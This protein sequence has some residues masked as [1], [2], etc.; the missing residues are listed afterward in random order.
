MPNIR[1]LLR[2]ITVVHRF[3]YRA[4]GGRVGARLP[5]MRFLLLHHVGR[6]SGVERAT[7]LLCIEDGERF[8]VVGSNAGD[9]RPPAW[10]LNLQRAPDAEVRFG[11]R[12][13]AVR[14]REATGE[15]RAALWA[16]LVASHPGFDDYAQR[17]SRPIPLVLLEPRTP[18][19]SS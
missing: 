10:W 4:S 12:R 14:A 9:D 1:W 15:E 8:A 11:T 19:H 13:L 18:A 3:V 7:P 6:R 16:R 5:G 2:L 17:T